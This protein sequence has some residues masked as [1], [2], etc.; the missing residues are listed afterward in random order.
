M[1]QPCAIESC[2]RASRAL[3]HC[4]QQNLCRDHL[5]EHDDILNGQLNP[6]ADEIN[7]LNDR[8]NHLNTR[9]LIDDL[10]KQ[11]EQYQASCH[12]KINRF[13]E[14]KRE[15][16]TELIRN[17]INNHVAAIDQ[18][19]T[20]IKQRLDN[21][22]TTVADL[23][24]ISSTIQSLRREITQIE[25]QS[26]DIDI[27]PLVIDD[28]LIQIIDENSKE[29]INL[30][31]LTPAV[32]IINR[33]PETSKPLATNNRLL[34]INQDNQLCLMRHD[35]TIKNFILWQHGWIWDMCWSATISR[36]FIITFSEIFMLNDDTMVLERLTLKEKYSF[37]ACTC[38]DTAFYVVTKGAGGSYICEFNL[39]PVVDLVNRYEPKADLCAAD[40]NIQD[41]IFHKGTFAFIIE[42][43]TRSTK[44]MELR[45]ATTFERLWSI[46]FD[47]VDPLNNPYRLCT[48]NYNEW[49]VIDCKSTQLF[50]ITKDGQIKSATPYP[51]TPYRC[52]QF[53]PNTLVVS[54]RQSINFHRL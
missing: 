18:V 37:T 51:S 29:Q 33:S 1:S 28:Q 6:Y 17:R 8:V 41:I 4:C 34:L 30:A 45:L 15:Q 24:S 7:E 12:E 31:N 23:K 36:F 16:L 22:D 38:S 5:N 11:L 39:T 25:H 40:E 14:K 32:Y 49:I 19:K 44:K 20:T 2:K 13:I 54:A 27:H 50:H 52:C 42:N 46:Q 26:I 47:L 21:Q 10:H 9:K 3:C 43:Q 35:M 48:F 53:G